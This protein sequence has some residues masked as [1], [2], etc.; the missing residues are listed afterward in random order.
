MTDSRGGDSDIRIV[1]GSPTVEEIAA[2]TAVLHATLDELAMNEATRAESSTTA[3]QRDQRGLRAA[4]VP[5]NGAW[6]GFSG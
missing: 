6:R 1:A 4:L 3:W 2:I 5:G